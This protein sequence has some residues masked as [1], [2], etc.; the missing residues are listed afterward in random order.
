MARD[1][2]PE[3]LVTIARLLEPGEAYLLQS[4]LESEGIRAVPAD[5][6]MSQASPW[7]MHATGGVRLQV[8]SAQVEGAIELLRARERGDFA[9]DE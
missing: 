9:L 7:L 1:A 6:H 4:F 3:D 2:L 5:V 8:P